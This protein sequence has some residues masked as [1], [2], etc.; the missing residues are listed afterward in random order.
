MGCELLI[1]SGADSSVTEKHTHI[2][3]YIEGY[4]FS[5]QGFSDNMPLIE[6]LL[7]V[8][9]IFI[10]DNLDTGQVYL[11]QLN[12]CIYLCLYKHDSILCPNQL[13]AHGVSVDDRN[14]VHNPDNE[15]VRCIIS[16]GFRMPILTRGPITFLLEQHPMTK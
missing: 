15:N 4:K 6:D 16:D 10:Y 1:D 9:T 5:V 7:I 11:L 3:E 8:N 2:L 12:H 13:R 14:R